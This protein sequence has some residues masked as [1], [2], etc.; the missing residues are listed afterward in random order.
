MAEEATPK[1]TNEETAPEEE[2]S[3]EPKPEALTFSK[4]A[5]NERLERARSKAAKNL[6]EE[7]GFKSI[8]EMR[9]WKKQA[10]KQTKVAE[11]ARKKE[12][13]EVEL[14]REQYE[15]ALKAQEAAKAEKE[16][17]LIAAEAAEI[18][19]HLTSLCAAKGIQNR[20]YAFFRLEEK[21]MA[22]GD[23]EE[24]DEGAF[25]DELLADDVQ[26][27]ALGVKSDPTPKPA[28]TSTGGS[29]APKPEEKTDAFDASTASP[30][31]FRKRL[32]AL[33]VH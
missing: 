11:E 16:Q 21:V 4:E 29:P 26:A 2:L 3:P 30:E 8:D 5:L 22:L 6:A 32:A 9:D 7:L 28:N 23:D 33:N 25:L 12:L 1:K 19:A 20:D 17:A 14:L 13:S 31:D 24:L 10:D 15:S 27:A 18:K